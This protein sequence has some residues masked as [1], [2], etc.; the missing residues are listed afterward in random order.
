LGLKTNS[1][2]LKIGHLLVPLT[3]MCGSPRRTGSG[4]GLRRFLEG[5]G[6]PV[7]EPAAGER[8]EGQ[9][10]RSYQDIPCGC[11]LCS[12]GRVPLNNM[13]VSLIL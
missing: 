11:S 4:V 12:T 1:G 2:Q 13:A 9:V 7:V 10:A 8:D 5:S 3:G 6:A